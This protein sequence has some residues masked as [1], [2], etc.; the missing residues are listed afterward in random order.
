MSSYVHIDNKN[1]NILIIGEGPA[2]RLDKMCIKKMC[3]K[4]IL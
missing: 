4:S 1:K 3:I 2:Q